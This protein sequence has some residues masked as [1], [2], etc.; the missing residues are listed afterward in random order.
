MADNP[1]A[2]GR[3]FTEGEHFALVDDAV[4]RET[5]AVAAQVAALTT[6]KSELTTQVDVLTTEK[7]AAE[8][9]ATAAEEAFTAYKTEEENKR[10]VA[11]RAEARKTELAAANPYLELT[12]ERVQRLGAMSDED[13]GV[14]LSEMREVAE[15]V[16]TATTPNPETKVE[17][18]PPAGDA[19][20]ETRATAAFKPGGDTTTKPTGTVLALFGA[21]AGQT[22]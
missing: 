2:G 16:K 18:T 17:E 14:Y 3:S 20:A 21:R 13:Y 19:S 15:K 4:K 1:Q 5:A 7:A 22:A 6:E 12:D 11:E 9:R 8:Q 10:Q